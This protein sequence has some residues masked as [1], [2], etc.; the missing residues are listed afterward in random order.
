MHAAAV[1]RPLVQIVMPKDNECSENGFDDYTEFRNGAAIFE[2]DQYLE[3]LGAQKESSIH[4]SFQSISDVNATRASKAPSYIEK[5]HE[6]VQQMPEVA[7]EPVKTRRPVT[8]DGCRTSKL[9]GQ[10]S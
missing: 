9:S 7:D 6:V 10:V 3:K 5:G 2:R 8:F 4:C 1:R